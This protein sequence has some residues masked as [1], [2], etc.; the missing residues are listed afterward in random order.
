M[1]IKLLLVFTV[2]PLIELFLLIEVGSRI[3]SGP[4]ILLLLLTG[5]FGA[6]LASR[7]GLFVLH[8]ARQELAQGHIP[9][10]PVMDG[11]MVLIGGMLLLTPGFLTDILGF[12]LLV[13]LSRL[14][15]KRMLLRILR[16]MV[17]RGAFRLH[18]Y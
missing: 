13:P 9:A 2:V 11:I 8:R 1:F 3:G 6:S 12:L 16:K 5:I 7:Q 17:A 18:H 14:F 15:L 4:T 10:N